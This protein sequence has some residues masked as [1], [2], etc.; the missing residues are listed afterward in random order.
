M[1]NE[2]VHNNQIGLR[3]RAARKEKGINQSELASLLGKSLRTIQKYESG[4]IEVSIAMINE[5]SK[6]LGCESTFLIGY[7][8]ERKPLATLADVM[9]FLFQLDMIKEI[10]F[11]IDVKRPPHHDGWECSIKFNGKNMSTEMNQDLCL[12]L[13][14]FQKQRNQLQIYQTSFEKYEEWQEK[15]LAYYTN[16]RLTEKGIEELS[17]EERIKKHQAIM[18]ARYGKKES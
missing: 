8:S 3:I 10:G 4:E 17:N 15:T 2:N 9:S 16:A 14:E 6:A 11:D 5:I 7:D 18:N 12:F 1:S 13:E